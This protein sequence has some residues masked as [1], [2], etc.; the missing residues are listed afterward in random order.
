MNWNQVTLKKY[1]EFHEYCVSMNE[2]DVEQFD[3]NTISFFEDIPSDEIE[4]F[5]VEDY[6]A[7]QK[8][9]AF[10]RRLPLDIYEH[11]VETPAGKLYIIEDLNTI[12]IGE[13]IDLGVFISQGK[14]NNLSILCS[15]LYRQKTNKNPLLYNDELEPYGNWI[16]KRTPLFDEVPVQSVFGII[17]KITS[18]QETLFENY[19]NLISKKRDEEPIDYTGLS[20][21]DIIELENDLKNEEARDQFGWDLFIYRLSKMNNCTF[22]Q[23]TTIP[24]L[25]AFGLRS[26]QLA[27]KLPDGF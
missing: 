26:M 11:S 5:S 8:K 4:D 6:Q 1:L 12:S 18:F 13:Y 14:I 24:L 3:I 10:A 27:F 15:I 21:A 22:E 25:Q 9:Y 20:K 7:L 17:K 16:Y 2:F 23:A 19:P